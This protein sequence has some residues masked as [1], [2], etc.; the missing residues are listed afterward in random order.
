MKWTVLAL[1]SSLG[2]GLV[3]GRTTGPGPPE[4]DDAEIARLRRRIAELERPEP[5]ARNG[6]PSLVARWQPEPEAPPDPVEGPAPRPIQDLTGRPIDEVVTAMLSYADTRLPGGPEEHLELLEAFDRYVIRNKA[7]LRGKDEAVVARQLYPMLAYLVQH[8]A[9][10][11]Q[12]TENVY[13]MMATDPHRL[14]NL[15]PAT[16]E[17]FTEG[18]AMLLPGAISEERLARFRTYGEAVLDTPNE[19][20]P[21]SVRRQKRRVRRALDRWW[22][23][24]I[25][26]DEAVVRLER[27]PATSRETAR[28]LRRLDSSR[29]KALDPV[30]VFGTQLQAG[31]LGALSYLRLFQLNP[32]DLALLDDRLLSGD[33]GGLSPGLILGYLRATGRRGIEEQ[34]EFFERA[35]WTPRAADAAAAER[36]VRGRR[37]FLD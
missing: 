29:L 14:E 7:A 25:S 13:E 9:E 24:P 6:R 3:I 5:V 34:R 2:L 32:G 16:L 11:V 31:D 27:G 19:D 8:D 23:E 10:V 36:I 33:G 30:L 4:R 20:L 17:L 12:L 26:A 35:R 1:A 15:D 18:A 28:L 22:A 37:L 21:T